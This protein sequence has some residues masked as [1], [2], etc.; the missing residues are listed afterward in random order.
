MSEL[1]LFGGAPVRSKPF[2][3]YAVIGGLVAV[4]GYAFFQKARKGF[5]DVL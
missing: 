3:A 5:A 1:A 2:P 4:I